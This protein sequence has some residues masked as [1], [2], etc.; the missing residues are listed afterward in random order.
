LAIYPSALVLVSSY[1]SIEVG[2]VYEIVELTPTKL[3]V[4]IGCV[5]IESAVIVNF[6][7]SGSWVVNVDGAVPKCGV[8]FIPRAASDQRNGGFL[9]DV[10]SGE[11]IEN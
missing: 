1:E 7:E 2:Y 10:L 5:K 9:S 6:I 4:K 3:D 11:I 8:Q